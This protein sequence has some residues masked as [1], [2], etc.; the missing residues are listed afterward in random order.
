MKS[1][2]S[3]LVLSVVLFSCS[4]K[5]TT[6]SN[7][8]D[9]KNVT[10][11]YAGGSL[12]WQ[13]NDNG[14][15]TSGS[16]NSGTFDIT[17]LGN[18]K[19]SVTVNTVSPVSSK[20]YEM[21]LFGKTE[22]PGTGAGYVFQLL[23]TSPIQKNIALRITMTTVTSAQIDYSQTETSSSEQYSVNGFPENK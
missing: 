7:P 18:N 11:H 15:Q 1:I 10:G 9:I 21:S 17:Y 2:A 14:T 3:I 16:D 8:Y 13:K 20:T 19:V 5:D 4:K 22:T 12:S 6:T 23:E